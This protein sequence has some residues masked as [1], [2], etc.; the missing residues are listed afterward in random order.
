[1]QSALEKYKTI[2]AEQLED[3]FKNNPGDIQPIFKAVR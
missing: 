1:M 2:F 3:Y